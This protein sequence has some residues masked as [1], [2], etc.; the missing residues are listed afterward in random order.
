MKQG[1]PLIEVDLQK[2]QKMRKKDTVIV[3]VTSGEKIRNLKLE[4]VQ[5]G[6]DEVAEIV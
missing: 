5:G 4:D 6:V 2:I 1:E 3:L